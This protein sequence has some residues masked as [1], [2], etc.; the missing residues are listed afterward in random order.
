MFLS[1]SSLLPENEQHHLV[2]SLIID[3]VR[4]LLISTPA[5][6]SLV[7]LAVDLDT[8]IHI[9]NDAHL[10]VLVFGYVVGKYFTIL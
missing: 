4:E 7:T 5:F 1:L 10:R 2:S 3:E 9:V 6:T 8:C